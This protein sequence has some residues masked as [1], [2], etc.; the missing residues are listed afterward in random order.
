MKSYSGYVHLPPGTLADLNETQNYP[1]NTFFW[2]FEAR[3]DP[4]NAP[5]SIWMNG[6]PGSSSLLGLLVENGP[7]FVNY[8]SNSTIHNEWSWNNEVNML[9]LDQPVQVGLSYDTL[10]NVTV[11]LETGRITE[12]NETD[13]IPEQNATLLV[14]TYPSQDANNTAFGSRNG[15]FALWHFAQTWFQ[16]F[17]AYA[18]NDSRISIATE[19]YG[20]RYG[21][22]YSAFFEEQNQKIENGTWQDAD[23]EMYIIHLD[24]LLLINS[25]VDR[26]VQ[27]NSYPHI[28][29][30]NTYGIETVNETIYEQ[31]TAAY[32]GEGGCRDRIYN[33]R[34]LSLEYDP[35]NRGHNASVNDV[36]EDAETFCTAYVRDPY[37]EYSGRN[38]YDFATFDP[39]PMPPPW[40]EG[41]LNQQWV[42]QALGV[43]L[44]WTQSSSTVARAFR[45]IGDYPRPGWLEDLAYLLENGIKVALVYGDRDFACNWIG[46]EAVS[47][48]VDWSHTDGFHASGYQ[49]IV[50]NDTF[51]GGKVRQYGNLSFSR[52][53]QAGHEVPYYQPEASY[54]IFTRALFNKD[55][56]TGEI[57]TAVNGSYH[58]EGPPDTWDTK[59]VPPEQPLQ[60]CYSLDSGATCTEDELEAISNGSAVLR[61]W[62]LEDANS[63]L[64]YPGI[65]S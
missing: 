1:I 23:G 57:D 60:V 62:I 35:E 48:A 33:C 21:P 18:P 39:D 24:T 6:G 14:G 29:Y 51:N 10:Q 59:N 9:Y 58:T 4:H 27:W 7:C 8:D 12:L 17:P 52:V 42:Q 61:D 22:A 26:N 20:G 19:S 38:Y 44:N 64:L 41:F 65:F 50:V 30:N 15:A 5:L 37:L 56:S 2:F 63:T 34:N 55:I 13:A 16:E 46:G 11:N 31:M 43:P 47:L 49:E 36:C 25:C 40:Y 54:K 45:S 53:Y 3:K 32:Y 28:A